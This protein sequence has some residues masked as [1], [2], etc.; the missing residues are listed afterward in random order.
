MDATT[1]DLVR[2]RAGERCEYCRLLQ[3]SSGLKHHIERSNT[4]A[5]TMP[6]IWRWLATAATCIKAPT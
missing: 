2:Q 5:L 3:E 1:R 6:T 4:A